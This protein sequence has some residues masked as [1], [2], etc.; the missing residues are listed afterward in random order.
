MMVI[1]KEKKT[2]PVFFLGGGENV[3][4]NMKGEMTVLSITIIENYNRSLS[5]GRCLGF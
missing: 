3:T 4:F 1:T 5:T 2:L